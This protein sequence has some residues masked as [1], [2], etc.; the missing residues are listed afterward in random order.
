MPRWCPVS[1]PPVKLTIPRI[2]AEHNSGKRLAIDNAEVECLLRFLQL[3]WIVAKIHR[4]ACLWISIDRKHPL[5][6]LGQ[7]IGKIDRAGRL[8]DPSLLIGE[9]NDFTNRLLK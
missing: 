8:P 5:A 1:P 7:C 3:V 6:F 2:L 4:E 9:S